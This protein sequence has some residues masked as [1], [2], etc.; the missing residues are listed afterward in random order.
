M[1]QREQLLISTFET[2]LVPLERHVRI[3]KIRAALDDQV[4]P[5]GHLL[6]NVARARQMDGERLHGNW[7]VA[8]DG[9]AQMG[10]Q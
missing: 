4:D 3:I 8:L 2:N 1:V 5:H 10:S 9:N 7:D 6:G